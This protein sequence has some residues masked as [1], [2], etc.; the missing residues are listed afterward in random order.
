M[1]NSNVVSIKDKSVV[2]KDLNGMA[3]Y[4]NDAVIVNMGGILPSAFLKE[5]GI[6]TVTK[7][8]TI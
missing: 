3:V 7:W 1:F 2:I 6:E 8:G 5:C 4:P